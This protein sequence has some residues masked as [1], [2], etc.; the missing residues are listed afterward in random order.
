MT[1][2]QK[3]MFGW[4]KASCVWSI[5]TGIVALILVAVA[6][7]YIWYFEESLWVYIGILA[8]AAFGGMQIIDGLVRLDYDNKIK[9]ALEDK[10]EVLSTQ[11]IDAAQV[12]DTRARLRGRVR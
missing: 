6:G 5:V 8:L 12:E 2:R 7:A 11:P 3:R 1:D 4:L 10:V 9:W